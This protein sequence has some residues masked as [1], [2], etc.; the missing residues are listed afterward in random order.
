M[1]FFIA[2]IAKLNLYHA[3]LLII[4]VW[5]TFNPQKF[6]QYSVFVLIYAEIF[7]VIKYIYTLLPVDQQDKLWVTVVGFDTQY[8]PDVTREYWRYSPMAINWIIV[9]LMFIY[10]RRTN[11]IGHNSQKIQNYQ[12]RINKGLQ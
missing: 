3:S 4:F 5:S 6:Q 10:Y 11:K 7:I 9:I 8:D 1:F 12:K 2:G